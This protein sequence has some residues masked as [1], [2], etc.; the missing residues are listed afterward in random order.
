MRKD[1][2]VSPKGTQRT[3]IKQDMKLSQK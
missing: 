1:V 3:K 2:S